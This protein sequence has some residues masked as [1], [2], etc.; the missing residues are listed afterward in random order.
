[1]TEDYSTRTVKD[2]EREIEEILK[3]Q[4]HQDD[5]F[6]AVVFMGQLDLAKFIYH[7]K[8]HQPE[9]RYVNGKSKAGELAGFGQA[10][11]Q[12]LLLMKTRDMDF[13]KVF[14]YAIEHMKDDEYM[15]K[16]PRNGNEVSGHPI[17]GGKVSGKAYVV[18]DDNPPEKAPRDSVVVMEHAEPGVAELLLDRKAVVT[19]QGSRLCH[20]AILARENNF[21]AI[22]GTGN[23][24]RLIRTGDEIIVDADTGKVFFQ[25]K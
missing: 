16:E 19:D 4:R 15:A 6:R 10:L 1:M 20:M 13:P 14:K 23:A 11:V 24:T 18:D 9:T 8:K 5:L 7:D 25:D 17:S 22:V 3:R 21:P 2:I 12:L